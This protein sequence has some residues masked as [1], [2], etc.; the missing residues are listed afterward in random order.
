MGIQLSFLISLVLTFGVN[1]QDLV[2]VENF[3][4]RVYA[5]PNIK[6]PSNLH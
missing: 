1:H 2:V 6:E 3:A 5:N 4:A